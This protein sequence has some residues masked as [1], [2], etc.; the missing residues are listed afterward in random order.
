MGPVTS[1]I[2]SMRWGLFPYWWSKPLKQV[3]R[4][5]TREWS[6]SLEHAQLNANSIHRYSAHLRPRSD[7]GIVER[8]G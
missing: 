1:P 6:R 3:R 8:C 7:A 5:S 2:S 4:R